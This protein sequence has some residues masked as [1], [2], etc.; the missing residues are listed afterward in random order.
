M[1]TETKRQNF[2]ITPKQEAE[3]TW[4]RETLGVSSTKDAILRAVR[5]LAI[6]AREAQQ[7][8]ALYLGTATGEL[9]RLLIPELQ[10]SADNGWE[11]L[12]ARPHPW[13]RQLYVKG[14]KLRAS[15]VWMDMQTNA[16][17]PEE[18]VDDWDL[19]LAAIE[20]IIRY[21]ESHRQLLAMEAEEERRRLLEEGIPLE[22]PTAR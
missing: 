21:C 18:A 15:T 10:S 8:R 20:E 9:T 5:V 14:R 17:T 16:M 11:Y 22:P 3:L 12:V 1:A 6:L 19:P 13:R 4:L 7:G 2:N